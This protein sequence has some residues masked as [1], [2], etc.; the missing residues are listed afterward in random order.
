L[1]PNVGEKKKEYTGDHI[2]TVVSIADPENM[3]RV[4]VKVR[5]LFDG[6]PDGDLPWATYK[7][8]V[9]V[10]PD[11]GFV[12]PVDVG[13]TVWVDF[14]FKGDTRYPRIT[15]GV[16]WC[17]G[18]QPNMPHDSWSGGSSHVHKRT[19]REPMPS[20]ST[21]HKDVIFK[22]HGLQVEMREG[23]AFSVVQLGTGTEFYI[24]P[25]GDVVVHV[26][27]MLL[28]SSTSDTDLYVGGDLTV[29]VDGDLSARCDG[30]AEICAKGWA[31]FVADGEVLVKSGQKLT[32]TGPSRT[33]IL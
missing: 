4:Q 10:R 11:D 14:P 18:Q 31:Q 29:R 20:G 7:L 24:H 26:E 22:Q 23:G 1:N 13:D 27:G 3:M 17:P 15:G 5:D 2:G 8:P 16:H 9:G 28:C 30:N 19:A 12:I 25:N 33:E 6:V 21:Y 32:L